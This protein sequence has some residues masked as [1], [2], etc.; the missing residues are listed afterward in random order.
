MHRAEALKASTGAR[1]KRLRAARG[2]GGAKRQRGA[3]DAPHESLNGSEGQR[4][5]YDKEA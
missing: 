1:A 4:A 2:R 3:A 5:R